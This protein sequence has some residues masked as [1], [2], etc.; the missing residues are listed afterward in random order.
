MHDEALQ[1]GQWVWVF[2][3]VGGGFPS[4]IFSTREKAQKWIEQHQLSGTLTAHPLDQSA[5]DW[6]VSRG[7]FKPRKP[8][9]FSGHFMGQ[10]SS[11]SQ[12]HEH[13]ENG[14][15]GGEPMRL[16]LQ[17]LKTI[18]QVLKAAAHGPF[19]SASGAPEDQPE[20]SLVHTLMGVELADLQRVAAQWPDVDL[21]DETVHQ[22]VWGALGNI[23]GYPHGC[24]RQWPRWIE[25]S[26]EQV[27]GVADRFRELYP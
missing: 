24:K 21:T 25:C 5:Y 14:F 26:A 17:E 20:A 1:K 23:I 2:N 13:F 4:G 15:L 22:A 11:A 19:F 7:S 8:E 3:G 9:H 16:N 10:F 27:D 6:A 12:P 18:G